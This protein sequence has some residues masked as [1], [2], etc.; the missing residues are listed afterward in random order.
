ML[1]DSHCH[2]DLLDR[3]QQGNDPASVIA[4]ANEVDVQYFLNVCV[5]LTT[6]NS[7]I[8]VAEQ[9]AHVYASVGVHPNHHDDA[10]T[11]EQ[12]LQFACHEKVIAIGETGLDYYRNTSPVVSQQEQFRLHIDIAKS[13]TK[14]LII[15][16]RA[17]QQDTI[18]IMKSEHAQEIGG[19]M[20]CF[21]EDWEMA[22]AA[23]DLGFYIS[24]SGIVT[25][26]NA[27]TVQAVATQIP[28]DRL[29]IETDSPYL[30]PE[31]MRGQANEPA[32]VRHTA[33]YIASLRQVPLEVIAT[34]TTNNF[35]NL[36]KKAG[37]T[38]V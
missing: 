30:A 12:L 14:P 6:V 38:H 22:K 17:A 28:L 33:A 16:T 15:H 37:R 9:F 25:F 24:I 3:E 27:K 13:L 29:L 8:S 21:T 32:Y 4:R 18:D 31:P 2:F 26:K 10:V 5:D 19:V 7:V 20:H 11:R 34:H 35:F 36:F 1:V 23:L